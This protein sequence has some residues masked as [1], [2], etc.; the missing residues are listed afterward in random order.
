MRRAIPGQYLAVDPKGRA[1]L[2]ASAEKNKIVYVL[3]RDAQAHLTI[4]S[5]LEA[6]KP[7]NLVYGLI[8][9]DRGFQNPVFA[10]IEVDYGDSE[11]D[12]PELEL[13][14]YELEKTLVYYVLDLG[15]NHVIRAPAGTVDRTANLLLQ[16]PGDNDGPS[17]V[18]VCGVE[19]VAYHH[20]HIGQKDFQQPAIHRVSLPQRKGPYEELQRPRRV[21]AGVMHKMKGAFFFLVQS[22]DGDL[23]KVTMDVDDDK[24]SDTFGEVQ[25]L[26]ISYFATVPVASTLLVLKS[27][28]LFVACDS[29]EHILYR[30]LG[31]GEDADVSESI[32]YEPYNYPARAVDNVSGPATFI[33]QETANLTRLYS[34]STASP[35][36]ASQVASTSGDN[37]IQ[38]VFSA[39]GTGARSSFRAMQHGLHVEHYA[40]SPLPAIPNAVWT[41]KLNHADEHDSYLVLGFNDTTLILSIG[42]SIEEVSES[43]SR[44]MPRVPTLAVQLLASSSLVQIH[45]RGIR[46]IRRHGSTDDW[47]APQNTT[48]VAAATNE[49]QIALGLSNGSIL[50]FELEDDTLDEYEEQL[51]LSG[52][53]TCMALMDIPEGSRRCPFLAVGCGDETVRVV[54]L[55]REQVLQPLSVQGLSKPPTALHIMAMDDSTTGASTL[56]LHIGLQSGLYLR[57]ILDEVTGRLSDSISRVLGPG[58]VKFSRTSVQ[59]Q[60]ALLAIS[61]RPWLVYSDF[62]TNL[63]RLTP[64]DYPSLECGYSFSSETLPEGLVGVARNRE[65]R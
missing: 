39:C 25:G 5:P 33:P 21:V 43:E 54:S 16:V 52:T 31:L 53:I 34:V 2:L 41:T 14:Q 40:A 57:V 6:H 55:N 17:G 50:Y 32:A 30:F 49:R 58:P 20:H 29:G 62:E 48:I 42:E 11:E 12:S 60:T 18:L 27:G 36:M 64:L 10:T 15:L 35:T 1:S 51:Q 26:K 59:Q 47:E 56:Y 37:D 13:T 38:K 8:A 63:L 19:H 44:F 65:L 23:F 3:N 7:H 46:L 61:T 9:L 45:H 28:L 4:S 22:E 24:A